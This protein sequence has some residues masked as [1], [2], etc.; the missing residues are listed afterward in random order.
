MWIFMEN[1][2][3]V[4]TCGLKDNIIRICFRTQFMAHVTPT[5]LSL[6]YFRNAGN[7]HLE[8]VEETLLALQSDPDQDVSFFASLESKIQ[9]A[10]DTTIL[11]K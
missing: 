5:F 9:T 11:E 1:V 7:H 8:V 2:F 6:A 4:L 3:N 10:I